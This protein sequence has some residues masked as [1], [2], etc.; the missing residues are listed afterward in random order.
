M[1][2]IL[3]ACLLIQTPGDDAFKIPAASETRVALAVHPHFFISGKP[4]DDDIVPGFIGPL[5]PQHKRV[6]IC[7]VDKAS[8]EPIFSDQSSDNVP[9][10]LFSLR[11]RQLERSPIIFVNFSQ[12]MRL[13]RTRILDITRDDLESISTEKQLP[14]GVVQ[15]CLRRK[16]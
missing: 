3:E 5:N 6:E 8:G 16:S 11:V 10:P 4:Q 1:N 2:P 14:W 9:P 12:D 15:L 13:G 7:V